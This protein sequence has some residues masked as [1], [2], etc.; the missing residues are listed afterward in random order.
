MRRSQSLPYL[1]QAGI[2]AVLYWTAGK[3]ALLLAIPPGYATAVWPAAGIAL[4]GVLSFGNRVWPGIVVGSFFVNFWTSVDATSATSILNSVSLT[5]SI[6]AGAALQAVVGASLVRRFV[7]FPT[8]LADERDVIK[9]LA[10]GGP[11][12]CIINPTVGVVSLLVAGAIPPANFLFNW[13]T[14]WVGDT[15]GV[16]IFAPL[17]LIW[18]GQPRQ[19]WTRRQVSM[20]LPLSGAFVLV[21]ILFVFTSG[22]EQSRIRVE[23]ERRTDNLAGKVKDTFDDSLEILY[24]LESFYASASNV[25]RRSFRSF[26]EGPLVRNPRIQA[27]SWNPF[28]RSVERETYEKAAQQAGDHGFQ[29]TEKNARG[30]LVPAGTRSQY[31][32][33]YYIEPRAD[34]EKARGFDAASDPVRHEA[35]QHACDTGKPMATAG[36]TLVQNIKQ[37][38]GLLVYLPIFEYELPHDTVE[39][40]RQNLKGY[41]AGVFKISDLLEG[42]L[43][44]VDRADIEIQLYD[45]TAQQRLLY[46]AAA[47]DASGRKLVPL[48]RTRT[49]EIAGRRWTLQFGATQEYLAAHRSLQAWSVLAGGLLFTGLL[50]AF[51]LVVTG[52]TAKIEELVAQRTAE[53]QNEII[54]RE[55]VEER[56]LLLQSIILAVSEAHSVDAALEIVLHKLCDATGWILGQAWVPMPDQKTLRCVPVWY[57][58]AAG[59][60]NFR[61]VS[62]EYRFPPGTGLPGRVWLLKQPL[63][64]QDVTNETNFPRAPVAREVGLKGAMGI[65]VMT[66]DEVVAVIEFFVFEPREEDQRF[67]GLV[68]AVAAQ[69]GS[70]IQRK[71]VEEQLRNSEKRL[72]HAQQLAHFGSWEWDIPANKVSWSNELYQIFGLNAR[73]FGASYEAFLDHV[74]PDDREFVKGNIERALQNHQPFGFDHRIVRPDG[75]E[76]ILHARGDVMVDKTGTPVRI[77]GSGQDITERKQGEDAMGFANEHLKENLTEVSRLNQIMMGREERILE[78]KEE[79]HALKS[80]F[81]MNTSISL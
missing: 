34:N 69:L 30:G 47:R 7:G 3:L 23:F 1:G 28:V 75:T 70:F 74:H 18:V 17:I 81:S 22:W 5:A 49:F 36:V 13:S 60:E 27:L 35:L 73:E 40:R 4:M 24:S 25:D 37:E 41:V 16:L 67:I 9:F 8:A 39:Q 76:R 2:V 52:R 48:Q 56:I 15:I 57:S 62:E 78:L 63:W 51:L 45:D 79:L 14:W 77:V 68:S 19:F 29:I 59:L 80:Q 66:G 50:G 64:I 6:G 32:P 54:E 21:V 44:P 42:S 58:N 72:T 33:V 46:G 65:P 12:S 20:T 53:L 55:Q 31:L 10:L 38:S 43:D 71:H 11:V 61:K 26:V